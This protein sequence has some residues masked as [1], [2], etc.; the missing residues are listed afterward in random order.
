[1]PQTAEAA[2]SSGVHWQSHLIQTSQP[3][4]ISSYYLQ[5]QQLMPQ[6]QASSHPLT[7]QEYPHQQQMPMMSSQQQQQIQ[8]E[9]QQLQQEMFE[10]ERQI[11]L[12]YQQQQRTPEINQR[13]EQFQQRIQFLRSR[14]MQLQQQAYLANSSEQQKMISQ[15]P[16]QVLQQPINM[17]T[18]QTHIMEPSLAIPKFPL[19]SSSLTSPG[20][21]KKFNDATANSTTISAPTGPVVAPTSVSVFPSGTNQVQVYVSIK[22][23]RIRFFLKVIF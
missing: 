1:M 17:H 15:P 18:H 3:S 8:Y 22:I 13:I 16:Q 10:C 2:S 6:Q 14:F 12:C 23:Y 20:A 5:S 7:Q 11:A 9:Q 21:S 19:S 4:N